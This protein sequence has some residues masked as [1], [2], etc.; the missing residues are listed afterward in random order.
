[1]SALASAAGRRSSAE[2]ASRRAE[3]APVSIALACLGCAL[4]AVRPALLSS[5]PH[6]TAVLV[7]MLAVLLVVGLVA[8]VPQVERDDGWAAAKR[9]RTVPAVCL[10]VAVFTVARMATGG[11]P[12]GP[13]TI[14]ALLGN[15]LA[16]VAEEV[17]F[18]RFVYGLLA[19]GG[20]VF[21]VAGSAL[22]FAA[23]HVTTYGWWV[24]PLDVAAGLV[25]GWQRAAT[26]SWRASA[27]T[28]VVANL[29]VL[30]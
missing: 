16:A 1:M 25:L 3:P 12:L 28:H 17:W 10:G 9:L 21:A 26:G 2:R 29:L 6:P 5:V 15:T 19:P 24:L 14:A 8:P 18:R 11:D 4:L 7:L 23:V 30:L 13:A 20:A 27:I 22:L